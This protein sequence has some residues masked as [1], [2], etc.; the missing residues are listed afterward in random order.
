MLPLEQMKSSNKLL[1]HVMALRGS[2]QSCHVLLKVSH[3]K[4]NCATRPDNR[5]SR[6]FLPPESPA[7]YRPMAKSR[8]V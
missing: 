6:V 3:A 5:K 4:K 2:P 1:K 7:G 8:G